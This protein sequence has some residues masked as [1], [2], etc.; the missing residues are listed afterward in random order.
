MKVKIFE[1]KADEIQERA[2]K[3]EATVADLTQK[4][5]EQILEWEEAKMKMDGVSE[6]FSL[7]SSIISNQ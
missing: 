6:Y 3:A 1:N 5:H 2:E 7:S 4:M